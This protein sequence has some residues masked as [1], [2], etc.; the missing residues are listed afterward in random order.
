METLSRVVTAMLLF[1]FASPEASASLISTGTVG[2]NSRSPDVRL[3]DGVTQLTGMGVNVGQVEQARPGFPV[4]AGGPDTAAK[5]NSFVRPVDVTIG[6]GEAVDEDEAVGTGHATQVASVIISQDTTDSSD[7]A[8]G[9][10]PRGV[11]P[12]AN[13]YASAYILSGSTGTAYDEALLTTQ[14]IAQI[15]NMR[16]INHS[17]QKEL[18]SEE[19]LMDGNSQLTLGMDWIASRYDVLNVFAGDEGTVRHLPSDNFNGMTIGASE[20]FNGKY[21]RVASF[22]TFGFDADGDRTSISLIAPGNLVEVGG[23]NDGESPES[24]TSFAVPHVTGTVALLQEYAENRIGASA[25]GWDEDARRHQVMKAVLMN[26]ADKVADDGTYCA[27][28]CLLGMER[29][30]VKQDG[31]SNWFDSL[32]YD[33][34]SEGFGQYVPLDE[35]MGTG[36][37]NARRAAIQFRPGEWD[38]DDDEIPPIGWDYGTTPGAG[39][40]NVYAFAGEIPAGSFVSITVAWDRKVEFATSIPPHDEFNSG[41]EFEEYT[42][43]VA[44]PPDDSV[45]NDLDVYLLPKGAINLGAAI[46]LSFTDVGTVEHLFFQ[47]PETGEYE[48]WINQWDDEAGTTQDYGVA[49]WTFA[50]PPGTSFGDYD[51]NGTVGANDYDVWK[52]NFGTANVA[53]DG[54]GNGIVDAADYTI[55]RDNLGASSGSATAVPEAGAWWLLWTA[56]ACTLIRRGGRQY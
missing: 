53:G 49:W 35:E 44:G 36:H 46:A 23:F 14:Y 20:V 21:Q 13:L 17:W 18:P 5:S 42:P 34:S 56:M 32:A 2:I 6:E 12:N 4:E 31:V 22:N 54:N 11:A 52:A 16:A 37:L 3:P 28:G 41:D 27:V 51:G 8:N 9:D 47:I 55:W 26:S 38:S 19:A 43:P 33:D 10:D 24:G 15:P 30:V 50:L 7:P 29:T 48:F 1:M 40:N 25:A 45:I 39:S